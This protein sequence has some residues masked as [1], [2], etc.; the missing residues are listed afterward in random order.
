MSG[1]PQID[2]T[3]ATGKG[4][5]LLTQVQKALGVTPKM[6]KVM[7]NSPALLEGYLA[8]SGA[9]NHGALPAAVRERLAIATAEANGCGYCLSAHIY[10]GANITEIDGD[11]LEKARTAQS[12]DSHTAAL[13]ALWDTIVRGRGSVDDDVEAAGVTDAEIAEVVEHIALNVLTNYFNVL[14]GVDNDWP[15]VSPRVTV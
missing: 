2:P 3:T 10:I 15:V 13:L 11:E 12:A 4:G 8:L 5:A 6:T 1:L 7:A 9:L 14:S